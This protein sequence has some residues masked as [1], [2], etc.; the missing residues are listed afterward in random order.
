MPFVTALTKGL[1]LR[2]PIIAA[3]LGRGSTP[4]FLGAVARRG[5]LASSPW[6]GRLVQRRQPALDPRAVDP[7]IAVA[8]EAA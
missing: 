4:E 6:S 5:L 3:P 8:D 7:E 1:G 2:Y